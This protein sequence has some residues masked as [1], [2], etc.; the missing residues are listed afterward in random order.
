MKIEK[1]TVNDIRQLIVGQASIIKQDQNISEVFK[2]L[3]E[4]TRTRHVY[5]VNAEDAI[6][7][8]VRLNDLIERMAPYIG[9][10]ESE[11]FNKFMYEFTQKKVSAI[12]LKEFL[13][14]KEDTAISEMI[15]TMIDNKV[16]ELPIVNDNNRIIGEVNLL[17]LVKYFSDNEHL[18]NKKQKQ[19]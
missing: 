11:M 13:F 2:C 6:V 5:V 10:L 1:R 19:A 12:M 8:S 4:D 7:G 9:Y 15:S 16:N 18:V 3:L 17:E 14:L